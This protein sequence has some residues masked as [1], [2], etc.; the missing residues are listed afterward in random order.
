MREIFRQ[1][2]EIKAAMLAVAMMSFGGVFIFSYL[3]VA[4]IREGRAG[5]AITAG[6][7]AVGLMVTMKGSVEAYRLNKKIMQLILE[8]DY[9]AAQTLI[10]S[11]KK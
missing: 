10:E 2:A 6:T 9:Q 5:L 4:C 3:M 8:K 7:F 1:L 11:M